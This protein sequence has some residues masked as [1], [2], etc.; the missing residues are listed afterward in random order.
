MAYNG[1]CAENI[2]ESVKFRHSA[3]RRTAWELHDQRLSFESDMAN[4][5]LDMAI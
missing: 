2:F 4:I 5:H 3:I 1:S